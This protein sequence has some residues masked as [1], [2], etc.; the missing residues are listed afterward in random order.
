MNACFSQIRGS[1]EARSGE[2]TQTRS[3]EVAR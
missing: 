2:D 1:A 3:D